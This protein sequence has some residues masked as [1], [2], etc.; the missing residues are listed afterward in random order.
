MAT[1]YVNGST[2][3]DATTDA[4]SDGGAYETIQGAFDDLAE[5]DPEGGAAFQAG[6]IISIANGTYTELTNP[7]KPWVVK[8]TSAAA[9]GVIITS[10]GTGKT[11]DLGSTT[12]GI[13]FQDITINYTHS[14]GSNKGA[15]IC[16]G[17]PL[18]TFQRCIIGST[19]YG[20][21]YPGNLSTF[22][23][24][25]FAHIAGQTSTYNHG[26]ISS[27]SMTVQSCLFLNWLKYAIYAN[28][29]SN[30]QQTIKN[31]TVILQS[32]FTSTGGLFLNGDG[33]GGPSLANT[34]IYNA[35]TMGIGIRV[36]STAD[37]CVIKNNL[38]Y[39]DGG[40]M[41][42]TSEYFRTDA[43]TT[44]NNWS[45]DHSSETEA[46]HTVDSGENL[47]VNYAGGDYSPDADGSAAGNGLASLAATT[48]YAGNSFSSPPSIGCY[49]QASSGWS[50]GSSVGPTAT[51]GCASVGGTAIGSISEIIGV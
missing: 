47:F 43:S 44:A 19:S 8:S 30:D 35:G 26:I 34:I 51:G 11:V 6:D 9:T 21:Y 45:T 42:V 17:A 37:V 16:S 32:G 46:D 29:G 13:T 50:G 15:I 5:N 23:R 27:R 12:S 24:C 49:E 33:S 18:V 48:D 3:D 39:N 10:S 41:T 31:C 1:Y 2:G 36:S 25:Q 20:V 38:V 22:D 4:T 14:K 28:Q 7:T 40:T